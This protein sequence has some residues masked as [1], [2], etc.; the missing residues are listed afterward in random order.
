VSAGVRPLRVIVN[1]DDFGYDDD[2]V[3]ATISAFEEGLLT[4]ATIMTNMPAS[5][6]AIAWAKEHPEFSFGVH[7]VWVGDGIER[8]LSPVDEIPSLVRPDGTF[9]PSTPAR[10]RGMFR[11]V[12][13][14]EIA[15]EAER[16][17]VRLRDAG[18]PVS[19]VDAHGHL[20]K[21]GSFRLA[22]RSLL[23]RLGIERVRSAQDVY[24]APSRRSPTVWLG[25]YWRRQL[26]RSFRTTDHFYMPA[27]D[28]ASRWQDELLPVLTEIGGTTEIGVHPGRAEAWRARELHELGTLMQAITACGVAPTDW[29]S[30]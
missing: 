14:V 29:R 6:A 17:I 4:S 27:S 16:Q 30:V 19:H 26:T 22:L 3:A 8:P 21:F 2:T 1:A 20:H 11:R 28:G 23:P 18:V 24:L 15:A 9:G 5:E 10:L 13:T 7:L 12:P 25:P